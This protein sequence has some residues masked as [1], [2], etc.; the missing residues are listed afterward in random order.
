[1]LDCLV[2]VSQENDAH[3][4]M[5][6]C[7]A[8]N[9]GTIE[10]ST[11]YNAA[12]DG[13]WNAVKFLVEQG[14][15]I[16]PL[17]MGYAMQ[18]NRWDV[19]KVMVERGG[20]IG[21]S[22]LKY[23]AKAGQWDIFKSML[24]K[25]DKSRISVMGTAMEY[26]IQAQQWDIFKSAVEKGAYIPY[27]AL[28]SAARAGRLDMVKFMTDKNDLYKKSFSA[29]NCVAEVGQWDAAKS[30]VEQGED[31]GLFSIGY[32]VRDGNWEMAQFLAGNYITSSLFGKE[33]V[34]PITNS[35]QLEENVHLVEAVPAL[36]DL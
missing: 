35:D 3:A 13:H 20:N 22:E 27:L 16:G 6:K 25:A 9:G 32:A 7:L 1:M 8:D 18:V 19:V 11:I 33:D 36:G 24:E 29:V 2:L 15:N 28:E 5:V 30:M 17:A 26:V 21:S 10:Y 4:K 14:G 34:Q 12:K 23:T 31:V